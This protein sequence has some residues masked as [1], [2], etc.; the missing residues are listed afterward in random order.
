MGHKEFLLG[1]QGSNGLRKI[2]LVHLVLENF[3]QYLSF[4]MLGDTHPTQ[5]YIPEH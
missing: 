2:L 3:I 5:H 4:T 1:Q